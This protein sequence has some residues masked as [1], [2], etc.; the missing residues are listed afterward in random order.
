M[1]MTRVAGLMLGLALVIGAPQAGFARDIC[2]PTIALKEVR[3]SYQPQQRVW[4]ALF[5][6]NA[7]KCATSAGRFTL[8]LVRLKDISPDLRFIEPATWT[9]G[10]VKV[11]VDLADDETIGDFGIHNIAPCLC[12]IPAMYRR[13]E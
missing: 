4:T 5:A 3:T 9:P 8:S 11:A 12:R 2:H 6:V 10:D 13:D 7:S 1:T